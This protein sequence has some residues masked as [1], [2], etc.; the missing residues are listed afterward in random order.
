MYREQQIDFNIQSYT[1]HI[2]KILKVNSRV[3]FIAMM[4][5]IFFDFKQERNSNPHFSMISL[6]SQ[7]M[8]IKK[9]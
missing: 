5:G 2:H 6:N 4:S 7:R 1:H 3:P 8:I 9:I